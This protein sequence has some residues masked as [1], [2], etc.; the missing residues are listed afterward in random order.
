MGDVT[1][2]CATLVAQ[3]SVVNSEEVTEQLEE[4]IAL[5]RDHKWNPQLAIMAS[6]VKTSIKDDDIANQ[7]ISLI[8]READRMPEPDLSENQQLAHYL[9]YL[10]YM[11]TF[12]VDT[13]FNDSHI[14]QIKKELFTLRC[15]NTN[16]QIAL[17]HS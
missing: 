13:G 10:A 6:S 15:E 8:A 9:E 7:L 16:T 17:K 11:E 12:D 4:N 5:L 2:K 3:F 1:G 14:K